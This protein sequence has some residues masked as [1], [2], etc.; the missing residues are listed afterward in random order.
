[1]DWDEA[2]L[3][4]GGVRPQEPA[5]YYPE[6]GPLSPTKPRRSRSSAEAQAAPQS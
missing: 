5:S 4:P 6:P 2:L 1:M 3:T